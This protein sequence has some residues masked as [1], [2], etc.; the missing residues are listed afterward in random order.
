MKRYCSVHIFTALIIS[1]YLTF[2]LQK[3][4][5]GELIQGMDNI[6]QEYGYS[7]SIFNQNI[8]FSASLTYPRTELENVDSFIS[9]WA[10]NL[11]ETS[12]KEISFLRRIT[13]RFLMTINTNYNSYFIGERYAGI[14]IFGTKGLS[15]GNTEKT[16]IKTFN[17]S[18]DGKR[19]LT[20]DEILSDKMY[21]HVL[22]C[23]REQII[24]SLGEEYSLHAK[25]LNESALNNIVLTHKGIKVIL[26]RDT[27]FPGEPGLLS[28]VIRYDDLGEA[29][30]LSRKYFTGIN[31]ILPIDPRRP[32]IALT[33]DDGPAKTTEKILDIL[34]ANNARATFCVLGNR[35]G[36][37][38]NEARILR[39]YQGGNEIIGHSWNHKQLTKLT[40]DE[41]KKQLED[42]NN[43]IFNIT[44]TMPTLHRPPYGSVNDNVKKASL[45]LNLAMVNWSIDPYDWKTKDAE[46]TYKAIMGS[47]K[48]GSIILCHDIHESTGEAMER[49][50]PELIAQGYQLVSVSEL[51]TF[52]GNTI[53]PGELYRH[54]EN[55]SLSY[56]S[57]IAYYPT[58]SCDELR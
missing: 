23:L 28:F 44:G 4:Y 35:I 39:A 37:E 16:L 7:E 27:C 2:T 14:E 45:D 19:L 52:G 57:Y 6:Y 42:T 9:N 25:K 20:N 21:D 41:I 29:F 40:Y 13:P 38:H 50:I 56:T 11:Y 32:I 48:N 49:V 18:V 30:K 17:I 24:H 58:S 36:L 12:R 47:V 5:A 31:P 54:A 8:N 43:A 53:E 10:N 55:L 1:I 15:P 51:L 46:A 22:E 34:E 3:V 33:F 26:E